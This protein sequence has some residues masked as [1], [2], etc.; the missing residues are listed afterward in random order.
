[1]ITQNCKISQIDDHLRGVELTKKAAR[2]ALG[3][4]ESANDQGGS[5]AQFGFVV[6]VP[7]L[8][9]RG[10]PA[11]QV[12]GG[13]IDQRTRLADTGEAVPVTVVTAFGP[14]VLSTR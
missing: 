10:K 13:S 12:Q 7:G 6:V 5:F 14:V 1:V 4:F 8:L 3:G 2:L 9:D 11:L